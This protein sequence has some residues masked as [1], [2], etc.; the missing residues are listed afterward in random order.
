VKQ[1]RARI[2]KNHREEFFPIEIRVVKGDQAWLSPFYEHEKSGSIA[3]HRY[4]VEDPL[5]YFAD[6]EPIYQPLG[7]RPHWG[8]MN[9]LDGAVF[10]ERYPRWKDFLAVREAL[11]PDG[12]LLNPYLRKV[13]GLG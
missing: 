2:E 11:D 1:V 13:F 9:T 12:R 10:A 8:K 3:V 4:H 6:I 5:P 7:G